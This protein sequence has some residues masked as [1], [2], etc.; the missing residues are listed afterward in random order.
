MD[1]SSALRM[2]FGSDTID[3]GAVYLTRDRSGNV[4]FYEV[5]ASSGGDLF[6]REVDDVSAGLNQVIPDDRLIGST[7]KVKSS[8]LVINGLKIERWDGS[9]VYEP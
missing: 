4:T 5:T 8:H 6:F 7:I 9:P 3:I 1:L 2:V